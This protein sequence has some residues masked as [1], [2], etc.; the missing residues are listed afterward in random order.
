MFCP[1]RENKIDEMIVAAQTRSYDTAIQLG[2]KSVRYVTALI[3]EQ[4]VRAPAVMQDLISGQQ[5]LTAPAATPRYQPATIREIHEEEEQTEARPQIELSDDEMADQ[6]PAGHS[7]DSVDSVMMELSA[8]SEEAGTTSTSGTTRRGRRK[9][10]PIDLTFSSGART[11][12]RSSSSYSLFLQEESRT[13]RSLSQSQLK[14][15]RKP[16]AEKPQPEHQEPLGKPK[17][18]QMNSHFKE[19]TFRK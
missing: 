1:R 13:T 6:T 8:G 4:A 9:K 2:Q 16:W 3:M 15:Q 18:N 7:G 12:G 10:V 14:N 17:T 11:D 5:D 19:S